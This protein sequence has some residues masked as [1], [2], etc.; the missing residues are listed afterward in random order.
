MN[1]SNTLIPRDVYARH[2]NRDGTTYVTQHRV[3]DAERFFAAR[4]AEAAKERAKEGGKVSIEQ[5]TEEQYRK[6]RM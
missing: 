4:S 5:I 1:P 2:T 6:E 3:W